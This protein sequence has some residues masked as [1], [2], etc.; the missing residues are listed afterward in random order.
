MAAF[1]RHSND[2]ISTWFNAN[3]KSLPKRCHLHATMSQ[4][5]D[6][7][8]QHDAHTV[9]NQVCTWGR[10]HGDG[11][12]LSPFASSWR[13]RAAVPF[14]LVGKTEKQ[15]NFFKRMMLT[16]LEEVNH[17]LFS[18]CGGRGGKGTWLSPF[19]FSW[20]LRAAVPF[21]LCGPVCAWC[22]H[23]FAAKGRTGG[24]KGLHFRFKPDGGNGTLQ[25]AL[26]L[27]TAI[28]VCGQ[29]CFD[30]NH[31]CTGWAGRKQNK[32]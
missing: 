16:E 1:P 18:H 17:I 26:L 20:R 13:L 10:M 22:Y 28:C 5:S 12:W 30:K 31:A 9:A 3:G 27:C 32:P 23:K 8:I 15:N 11:A 2:A 24:W 19:A 21:A 4:A 6:T 14:A 29:S 25:L 7:Y